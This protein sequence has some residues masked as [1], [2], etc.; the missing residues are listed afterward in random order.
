MNSIWV[1][2]FLPLF[3]SAIKVTTNIANTTTTLLSRFRSLKTT[4][5]FF[6]PELRNLLATHKRPRTLCLET[7][8]NSRTWLTSMIQ[9]D[10][11][12]WLVLDGICRQTRLL[13]PKGQNRGNHHSHLLP[14][15]SEAWHSSKPRARGDYKE[16]AFIGLISLHHGRQMRIPQCFTAC[17]RAVLISA[18]PP[19]TA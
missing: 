8:E 10:G 2:L 18:S 16:K 3:I 14:L 9:A 5:V 13:S 17:N 7:S 6:F 19:T 4:K 11:P 1:S 12:C 15:P